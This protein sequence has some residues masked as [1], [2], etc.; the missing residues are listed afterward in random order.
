MRL[1][2]KAE[3]S[4]EWWVLSEG[5]GSARFFGPCVCTRTGCSEG[6]GPSCMCCRGWPHGLC[7]TREVS[8]S[9]PRL[10]RPGMQLFWC[11]A[12]SDS[13]SSS[14]LSNPHVAHSRVGCDSRRTQQHGESGSPGI[15]LYGALCRNSTQPRACASRNAPP[16]PGVCHAACFPFTQARCPTCT[17]LQR[18]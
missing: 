1:I 5:D 11:A 15:A 6:P 16:R 17:S 7:G 10:C 12:S 13:V 18:E 14:G 9:G 8:Q 4:G 2:R 3:G